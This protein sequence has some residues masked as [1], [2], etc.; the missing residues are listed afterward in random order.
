[1]EIG[2]K[3]AFKAYFIFFK[4]IFKKILE[5][6]QSSYWESLL[7]CWLHSELTSLKAEPK[8]CKILLQ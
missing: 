7:L 3:I 6:I 1:M 2:M 8:N 5:F 4:S